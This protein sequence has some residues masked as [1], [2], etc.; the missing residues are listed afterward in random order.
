MRK[1]HEDIMDGNTAGWEEAAGVDGLTRIF[2]YVP[3]ALPPKDFFLSAGQAK[4]EAM[5]P[6]EAATKR[7]I[8][9]VLLGLLAAMY[10]AWIGGRRFIK[11]PISNLLEGTAE[12]GKGNYEARV[13]IDDS[14]SEIG[15]LGHAFNDMADALAARHQAQQ[16]AEEELR[17]LNATLESR[18]GRRTLELE[19]ANRAKSQFLAK[20]SH[21]IRTPVN[22]VLGMLELIV[23]TKLGP[24]Q[25]RYVDT[26]RRS[27]EALLGII[28][29]ILDI[30]KIEAGK[31]EL[32]ESNFDLRDVVE[33]V[34]ET[35]TDI[36][37][38]KGLELN[39]S[40]PAEMPMALVGDSGRLRQI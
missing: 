18:I 38:G 10:L 24:T 8:F 7:G 32:D 16:R 25:R 6:I 26:A 21:E 22:G 4:I 34:T 3:V 17:H 31:V 33:E 14:A 19:E 30:S 37:Y 1:S 35:F 5:E 28:N 11:R 23:Q 39:C 12:W 27:A 15:R 29:G 9:L 13:K 40:I 2:G 36:A 20:M